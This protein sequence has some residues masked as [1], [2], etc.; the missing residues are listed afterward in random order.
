MLGNRKA[1][2][3]G[4]VMY[5]G[6]RPNAILVR[7]GLRTFTHH[8]RE[9]PYNT[10]LVGRAVRVELVDLFLI[11]AGRNVTKV[12]VPILY[13]AKLTLYVRLIFSTHQTLLPK[14]FLTIMT[15]WSK[16]SLDEIPRGS[17]EGGWRP[18]RNSLLGDV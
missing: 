15:Y 16:N 7:G 1:F 9:V 4:H 10:S 2:N 18:E 11:P 12:A 13:N 17:L 3:R 5:S 8:R 6:K 14:G